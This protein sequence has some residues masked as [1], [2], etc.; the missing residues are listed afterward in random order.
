MINQFF[1]QGKSTEFIK[2]FSK[3]LRRIKA[4]AVDLLSKL[5]LTNAAKYKDELK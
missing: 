3:A 2:I 5:D 4:R 1:F